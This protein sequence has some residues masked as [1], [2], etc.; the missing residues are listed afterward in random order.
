MTSQAETNHHRNSCGTSVH[1]PACIEP[2]ALLVECEGRS[3]LQQLAFKHLHTCS[4][5]RN[6]PLA[7]LL[8]R[9]PRR[10]MIEH[11]RALL[12]HRCM[13]RRQRRPPTPTLERSF[14]LRLLRGGG[15][16]FCSRRL[17]LACAAV[18]YANVTGMS[19]QLGPPAVAVAQGRHG[20]CCQC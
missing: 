13:P 7:R 5:L 11:R 14:L 3:H 19:T 4:S 15:S 8:P 1:C 10:L 9:G 20:G 17:V 16:L 12:L 2:S 6:A 18:T